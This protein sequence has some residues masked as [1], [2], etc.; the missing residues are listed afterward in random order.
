MPQWFGRMQPWFLPETCLNIKSES[1]LCLCGPSRSIPA[2]TLVQPPGSYF[3]RRRPEKLSGRRV[4]AMD[5]QGCV[6]HSPTSRNSQPG[7]PAMPTVQADGQSPGPLKRAYHDCNLKNGQ[8]QLLRP[9]ARAA[10]ASESYHR[11]HKLSIC[12]AVPYR[13][14]TGIIDQ[15]YEIDDT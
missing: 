6:R 5:V 4:S 14:C 9:H 8:V 3:E 1:C 2:F 15:E 7:C 13:A 10:F 11:Y 12:N